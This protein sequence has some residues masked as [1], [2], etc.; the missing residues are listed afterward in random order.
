[1]RFKVNILFLSLCLFS[2]FTEHALAREWTDEDR[3]SLR[4]LLETDKEFSK[5]KNKDLVEECLWAK[6]TTA[7]DGFYEVKDKR[8]V[9]IKLLRDCLYEFEPALFCGTGAKCLEQIIHFNVEV[10]FQSDG[11]INITDNIALCACGYD[12]KRGIIRDF[13]H[14]YVYNPWRK[15]DRKFKIISVK[16]NGLSEPYKLEPVEFGTETRIGSPDIKIS[17]FQQ[18]EIKYKTTR[19]MEFVGDDIVEFYWNVTGNY[20]NYDI[21]SASIRLPVIEGLNVIYTKVLTGKEGSVDTTNASVEINDDWIE[22]RTIKNLKPNEGFTIVVAY[23]RADFERLFP[24]ILNYRDF[25]NDYRIEI[26]FVSLLV[27]I[28]LMTFILWWFKI[29]I[30]K[31]KFVLK[32]QFE[33]PEDFSPGVLG[34]LKAKGY[35]EHLFTAGVIQLAVK[36]HIT[37]KKE[38]DGLLLKKLEGS[39][40]ELSGDEDA[41]LDALFPQGITKI[42]ISKTNESKRHIGEARRKYESI[43]DR[44]CGKHVK[45]LTIWYLKWM[46]AILTSGLILILAINYSHLNQIV[47]TG[48][49]SLLFGGMACLL[50][51]LFLGTLKTTFISK[52]TDFSIT[53]GLLTM[54]GGLFVLNLANKSRELGWIL[55]IVPL[56]WLA[57][58]EVVANFTNQFFRLTTGLHG[59]YWQIK[60]LMLYMEVAEEKLMTT[61]NKPEHSHEHFEKYLPYAIAL[62][63]DERWCKKYQKDILAEGS[64]SELVKTM[65]AW[66][67]DRSIK[68]AFTYSNRKSGKTSSSSGSGSSRTSSY[69]SRSRSSSSGSSRSSGGGGGG[70]GGRGW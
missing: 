64:T 62:K 59:L 26:S 37:I 14:R 20:W 54:L 12:I 34:Y 46:A 51:S 67:S 69:S 42:H 49:S 56:V 1:M 29:R 3:K 24:E 23:N 45:D 31:K 7:F 5:L 19:Q 63:M 17:G 2:L 27:L 57:M 58:M 52:P 11:W 8:K 13:P 55:P 35:R 4:I 15:E 21:F 41:L 47:L 36:K 10:E 38:I 70:G 53:Y 22:I 68:R 44:I 66:N 39:T 28:M 48:F 65:S 33:I 9:L 40:I 50:L 6:I 16:R 18:Y 30:P 61:L 25:W 32:P 43:L 60:G